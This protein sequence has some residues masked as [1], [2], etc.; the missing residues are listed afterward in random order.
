VEAPGVEGV[1]SAENADEKASIRS[2]EK[3]AVTNP[4]PIDT[5]RDTRGPESGPVSTS[6]AKRA[7]I[8]AAIT[9]ALADGDD[10]TAAALM[11]VLPKATS[12][13]PAPGGVIPIGRGRGTR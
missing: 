10:V 6:D 2:A 12:A 11:A 9:A 8:V 5:G 7:A 4:G 13:T 1:L 3:S